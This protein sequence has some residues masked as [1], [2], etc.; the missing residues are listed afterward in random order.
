M[1]QLPPRFTEVGDGTAEPCD[2]S[3][4][5]QVLRQAIEFHRAGALDRAET[6][7]RTL[8]GAFPDHPDVLNLLGVIGHQT[9]RHEA[10]LVLIDRAIARAP[11]VADYHNN[12]GLA[13]LSLKRA[14][15][16]LASFD[17]AIAL[18]RGFADANS[19]AGN[20][21]QALDRL[22]DAIAAYRRAL[23]ANPRHA[24]ALNN[25]G[26]AL[27]RRGRLADAVACWRQAIAIRPAY[28]E[29]LANLGIGLMAQDLLEDAV[30][31]F[32]SSL[33]HRPDHGDT[34]AQLAEA[35]R[36]CGKARES[37]EV[38]RRGLTLEPRHARLQ[39]QK[40]RAL[41]ALQR[42][43]EALVAVRDA[44]STD[45]DNPDIQAEL[46]QT[47]E[48]TGE[49][50]QAAQMWRGLLAIRPRSAD[51][52]AG[53]LGTDDATREQLS[54]RAL[55]LADDS[56]VPSP[57]RRLLHK[58]LG[59]LKDKLAD[60]TGAM[61]HYMAANELRL[62]ELA[63]MGISFNLDAL[64]ASVDRQIAAFDSDTIIRLQALGS[65][66]RLPVFIVGM[67]RSGT[68]LC[69][70]I[71]ASHDSVAG[72]GEL[73][74]VQA[75]ARDLPGLPGMPPS[76]ATLGYPACVRQMPAGVAAGL[77]ERYL[78]RLRD[79]SASA[80]RIV[81]K[82]PINFRHLGLISVL[83]PQAAIIHCRRDPMDTCLSCFTQNFD[84]PIPWALRQE[85]LGQY[86][87]E[88]ERLFAHWNAVLPGRIF[89]FAYEDAVGDLESVARR[90]VAHCG[91][92]WQ[93]K[94]LMFHENRR[95]VRTA[96]H[97]Q[98]R[99]ALYG[100]SIGRWRNYAH[101]LSALS[102]ALSH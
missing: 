88:Y 15:D 13:L 11:S 35:L 64:H 57:D 19:N 46:G 75:I 72:A 20:A 61:M 60:Y 1:T 83:F 96:S 97:R 53:L 73:N 81:D 70:Q 45:P 9:N 10:A 8:L 80:E 39:I 87:R 74:E 6:L 14:E 16:A 98:V 94:C 43:D 32:E 27:R 63:A 5:A 54:A 26:N 55:S 58:A 4:A 23:A 71:L 12:R 44:L 29:A 36:L 3:D 25:L 85:T 7:Y 17:R 66:S 62:A 38:C 21:L 99:Q 91:I 79:V 28:A 42:A 92:E 77:C 86:Y 51:A 84:A 33:R 65:P 22:D 68:S 30:A 48:Y 101:Q 50:E 31:V 100:R 2:L 52:I 34:L 76:S 40:A 82:H 37:L 47:L 95:M 90:L 56:N 24:E 102:A 59:D 78:R 67:P 93:N 41:G 49:R 18:R 89:E 69:E